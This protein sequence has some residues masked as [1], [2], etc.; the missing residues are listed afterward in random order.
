ML[1]PS[2]LSTALRHGAST[3]QQHPFPHSP[4]GLKSSSVLHGKNHFLGGKVS[5]IPRVG[6]GRAGWVALRLQTPIAGFSQ[7]L[8]APQSL[9]HSGRLPRL[10]FTLIMVM[11]PSSSCSS[12]KNLAALLG[13]HPRDQRG[14]GSVEL[15]GCDRED[16]LQI[17]VPCQKQSVYSV[18]ARRIPPHSVLHCPYILFLQAQRH[19]SAVRVALSLQG[20]FP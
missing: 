7:E 16:L 11:A 1:E 4:L 19:P 6:V 12:G 18:S 5:L 15:S 20:I 17:T 14:S 10:Y 9:P 13:L 3:P 8:T 2:Y